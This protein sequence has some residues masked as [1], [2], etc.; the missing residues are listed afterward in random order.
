MYVLYVCT[1]TICVCLFIYGMHIDVC[2]YGCMHIYMSVYGVCAYVY[3]CLCIVSVH[4]FVHVF[5]MSICIDSCF[6][7]ISHALY[8]I[9]R[10]QNSY[11]GSTIIQN[12]IFLENNM[13]KN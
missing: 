2:A 9:L 11:A 8:Y 7:W 4:M 13:L 10:K 1:Y 6:Q 5:C 3:V 12:W